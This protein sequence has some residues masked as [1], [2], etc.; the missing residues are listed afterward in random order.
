MLLFLNVKAPSEKWSYLPKTVF[1]RVFLKNTAFFEKNSLIKYIPH[2][3]C[4]K[5]GYI[6]IFMPLPPKNGGTPPENQFFAI[7]SENTAPFQN[8]A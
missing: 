2:L 7:F 6:F 1:L 5:K 8:L 3:I 4:D